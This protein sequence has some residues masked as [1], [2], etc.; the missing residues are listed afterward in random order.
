MLRSTVIFFLLLCLVS[1]ASTPKAQKVYVHK[2]NAY[3]LEIIADQGQLKIY[4]KHAEASLDPQDFTIEVLY[5]LRQKKASRSVSTK[6]NVT[7][8]LFMNKDHFVGKLNPPVEKFGIILSV[9]Y[10]Q[11]EDRIHV[12]FDNQSL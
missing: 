10:K 12:Y 8:P 7:V 6:R 3:E 1:C 5:H 2:G 11:T 9:N 4:P